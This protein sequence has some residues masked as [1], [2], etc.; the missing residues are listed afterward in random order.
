[1]I[2]STHGIVGS[3]IAQFVG[4]LDLYPSAAAAYSL[5]KLR[6]A[7]TG[8]AI[9]VRR[10]NDN[11]EQDIGFVN[12]ELDTSSLT[13][14]CGVNNGFVRTWYDQSGNGYNATQTTALLQ[15]KIVNAGLVLLQ[16][17]KPTINA[18]NDTNFLSISNSIPLTSTTSIF[19]TMGLDTTDDFFV[20]L[21]DSGGDY[22]MIANS[23]SSSN[24]VNFNVGTPLI[25]KNSASYIATTRGAVYDDFQGQKLLTLI[26]GSTLNLSTFNI[27]YRQGG[28]IK[29]YNSQEIIIY[30]SDETTNKSGIE[31]NINSFYSIY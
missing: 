30:N 13:S 9:R 18:N 26:G 17:S 2:L 27:G 4:L 7:Y 31:N 14:F 29:M 15:P 1:M 5:R 12:N 3:Q 10:S 8:S 28:P 21:S 22:F 11:A 23:Q 19:Y 24:L 6:T 25:F 16:N 20:A